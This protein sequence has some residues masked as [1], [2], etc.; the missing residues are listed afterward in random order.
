[1][2]KSIQRMK[3]LLEIDTRLK[4]IKM[5]SVAKKIAERKFLES[6]WCK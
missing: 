6:D 3:G 4:V 5:Q 1:M 2:K